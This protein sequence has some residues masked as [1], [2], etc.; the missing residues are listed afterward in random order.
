MMPLVQQDVQQV[1]PPPQPYVNE[2]Q[3]VEI[4]LLHSQPKA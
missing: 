4:T 1:Y 3:R 2:P